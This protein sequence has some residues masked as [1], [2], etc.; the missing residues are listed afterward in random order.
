VVLTTRDRRNLE[1]WLAGPV[2]G[3][4]VVD[5]HGTP[6]CGYPARHVVAAAA[7]NGVRLVCP[8]RP[9]YGASTPRPDRSVADVA[10]DVADVLDHL[11]LERCAVMGSSGGGPHALAT[12]ARLPDRVVAVATI[13]GAGPYGR[14]DLD[15]LAGMG[16]DNVDEFG[17]ALVGEQPLRAFL[18]GARPGLLGATPERIVAELSTLLPEPDRVVLTSELGEDLAAS[19]THALGPG[20]E[21]WLEDDLAFIRPWRFDLAEVRVPAFVWQGD[22]DL[23]VPV[24]H[25]RWL[26]GNLA[27]ATAHLL[28]GEGHLSIAAGRIDEI[29]AELVRLP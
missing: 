7:R 20:V 26:A 12:A 18:D 11:S 17:A 4:P 6:S 16:Q 2:D 28:T 8:T 24:A 3:R 15:F 25:G 23:M 21:G 27:A 14:E 29:L 13:A 19:I 5:H 22:L 10:E 1:V 9:G